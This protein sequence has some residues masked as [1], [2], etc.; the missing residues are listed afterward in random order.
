MVRVAG[1]RRERR[2][3]PPLAPTRN[4]SRRPTCCERIGARVTRAARRAGRDPRGRAAAR[5]SSARASR[6]VDIDRLQRRRARR[7]RR[8]VP[9]HDLPGPD[10]ARGRAGTAVPVHLEPL[11]LAR[12]VRARP[13]APAQRRFARVKVPEVLPRFLARRLATATA[14]CR[15]S[16]SSRRTSTRSSPAWR[17]RSTRRSASRATP[18]SRSRRP[19]RRPAARRSSASCAAAASATVVRARGR[20]LDAAPAC[21]TSC[22]RN[23]ARR[24][25]AY[26]YAADGLLDLRRPGRARRRCERP[27]LRYPEWPGVDAARACAARAASRA[28]IFAAIREGDILVHHPYDSFT[29]SVERFIDAGRRRPRRARDQAHDLPH[30]GRLAD[31]AE[32]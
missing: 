17:S 5:R 23:L 31:G 19:G 2:G 8:R 24:S 26:V 21:A 16:S 27:D 11:A 28:D 7:A 6:I 18:T 9:R 4:G 29:T 13:R 1:L 12:R 20:E 10:A 3:R 32:R 15:S 14:S 25:D 30:V 22:S